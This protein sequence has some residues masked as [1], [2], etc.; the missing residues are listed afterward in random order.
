MVRS[1]EFLSIKSSQGQEYGLDLDGYLCRAL[2]KYRRKDGLWKR[3]HAADY[4]NEKMISG[5]PGTYQD[6]FDK[7]AH[8]VYV[9]KMDPNPNIDILIITEKIGTILN[10]MRRNWDL[11]I[12]DILKFTQ[13]MAARIITIVTM[14]KGLTPIGHSTGTPTE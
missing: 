12:K 5:T 2:R 7:L 10:R 3:K 9:T 13:E 6:L 4:L 14:W 8:L 1:N 11:V